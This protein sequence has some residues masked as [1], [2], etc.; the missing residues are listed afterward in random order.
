[1]KTIVY[2]K[3]IALMVMLHIL[4]YVWKASA[5]QIFDLSGAFDMKMTTMAGMCFLSIIVF[6]I[7]KIY[8]TYL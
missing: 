5:M 1:M 4:L 3:I 6:C 7:S 2:A 8:R